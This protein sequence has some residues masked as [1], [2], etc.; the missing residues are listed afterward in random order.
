MTTRADLLAHAV[1]VLDELATEAGVSLSDDASGIA[2]QLDA[3]WRDLGM[4]TGNKA[5][6]EALVEYHVLRRLRYAVASRVDHQATGIQR[7]R[8]QVYH[9]VTD[10]LNDAAARAA[11]AGHPVTAVADGKSVQGAR[12][13]ALNLD[14]LEPPVTEWDA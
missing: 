3:A 13:V 10:L 4:D 1:G 8:S 14:Y 12:L 2:R 6:A 9:Q 7:N 11:A 5:A